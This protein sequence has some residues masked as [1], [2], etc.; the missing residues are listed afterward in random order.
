MNLT[1]TDEIRANFPS[2]S[3]I[4]ERAALWDLAGIYADDLGDPT[5]AAGLVRI[6]GDVLGLRSVEDVEREADEIR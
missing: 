3:A 4:R 1:F 5:L 2:T 6:V